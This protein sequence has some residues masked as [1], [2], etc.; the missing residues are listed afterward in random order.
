M[1]DTFRFVALNYHPFDGYN[2]A[3]AANAQLYFADM[4]V[5]CRLVCN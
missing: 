1:M 5:R 4:Q 3:D 2:C